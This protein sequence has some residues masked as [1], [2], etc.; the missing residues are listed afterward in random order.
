[1]VSIAG[2]LGSSKNRNPGLGMHQLYYLYG[3]ERAGVLGLVHR[4]GDH[5]WFDRG[6]RHLI[7][8]QKPNGSWKGSGSTAGLVPD[9]CFALLFLSRGTTPVVKLPSRVMTGVNR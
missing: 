4:F 9:T 8:Q 2:F 6:A 3:L 1:M 7:S 5:E